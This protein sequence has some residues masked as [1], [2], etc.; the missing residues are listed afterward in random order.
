MDNILDGRGMMILR[1]LLEFFLRRHHNIQGDYG[2][3]MMMMMILRVLFFAVARE[4]CM[5]NILD[6]RGMMILRALLGFFLR[7]HHNI[8]GDYGRGM[9][10]MMILRVLFFAVAREKYMDNILDGRGMMIL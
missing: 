2:Q 9:M 7:R 8:Q 3:G 5:D 10:M 4:K 1:A 6:G